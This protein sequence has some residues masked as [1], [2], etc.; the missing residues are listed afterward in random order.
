MALA[1][2]RRVK[3]RWVLR[4]TE[5]VSSVIKAVNQTASLF[6]VI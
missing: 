1:K 4:D 5:I 2:L 3:Q 6:H